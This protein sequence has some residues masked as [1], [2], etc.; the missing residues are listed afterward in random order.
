MTQTGPLAGL[1]VVDI[2]GDLGRFAT[3]LLADYGA[4]VIRV[5]LGGAAGRQLPL[6][7]GHAGGVLDW[8]YDGAKS[9]SSL[10]LSHAEGRDQ[11]CS[12]ASGADVIVEST[13]PGFLASH[14]IDHSDLVHANPQ[15]AQISITPFGRTG[16]RSNWHSSD[17]V[18]GALGGVMSLTGTPAEPLNSWGWQNYNFAGFAGAICAMSAVMSARATGSG[19][20]VDVSMHEVVTGS[21]ENLFMQYLYDDHLDL[22]KVA[23]RQGSLHWL[24]AYEVV[25]ARSGAVMITPTPQAESLVDWM[26]ECGISQAEQFVGLDVTQLLD[27]MDEV[28]A[29]VKQFAAT[30]DAGDLFTQAQDRHIAFGEVQTVAQLANNPQLEHRRFYHQISMEPGSDQPTMGFPWRP[31]LYSATPIPNPTP[32]GRDHVDID[33]VAKRWRTTNEPRPSGV[34][35]K[36][37]S[38]IGDGPKPLDGL[39]IVDLSWVLAGPF[40]TRLLGDLGAEVIKVQ[41]EERATLVN[42][43]DY[44]YYQVWNRSKH[45]ATL[46]LK[47]HD[48]PAT[49]K[50]LIEQADVVVENYSAGVLDRLGLGWQAAK[51]W[52]DQLIY[53]SMSGCGHD[54]PWADIISY[55]PTVH[56]LCGLTHLTNPLGRQDIGCGFSLNDHA[57]GFAAAFSIL[58]AL[59]ARNTTRKGQYIDM[60]Q[61][62]VGA[63]L[64]GPALID[65]SANHHETQP[66][67]NRDS[68]ADPVPNEVY[69]GADQAFVAISAT[70]DEMWRNLTSVVPDLQRPQWASVQQRRVDRVE[71][72]ALLSQWC[73]QHTAHEAMMV[74]QQGGVAA[75]VVQNAEDLLN[76]DQHRQRGFWLEAELLQFGTRTHDRFPA[77]WSTSGDLSPYQPA[78]GYLGEANFEVW[79]QRVGLDPADVAMGIADGLFR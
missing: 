14:G 4:E 78:P 72:D 44:P 2:T 33:S 29:T 17:L 19:Q 75:G 56:A 43:P 55:A 47:H 15:L 52:N 64:M 24:G 25:P 76:D 30:M 8:W 26:V 39:V 6:P 53:I 21:I 69:A 27:R 57:A 1:K 40:S 10:S 31:V 36:G 38:L 54:G 5:D 16:D 73:S 63:Y 67:G 32:P 51:Q 74:L 79:A 35:S 50:K 18:A 22:P 9:R 42:Q 34:V 48:G 61:L 28:M 65:W 66:A 23:Q 37:G 62:E 49:I 68:L 11:Y 7:F 59:N 20:L 41:H 3:K 70:D 13:K 71:V 45:S 58:G 77:I 60:A 46:D 12:L